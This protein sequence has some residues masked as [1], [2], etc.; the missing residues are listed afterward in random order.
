LIRYRT[1]DRTRLMR[2][3]CACG[4][5]TVRMDRVVGRTDDM[6]IVRGVNVFPS[7]IETVLLQVGEVAPHY[8]IIVD[9]STKHIDELDVLVE[10]PAE[11]YGDAARLGMLEKRLSY[12]VQSALGISCNVKLTAPG[13]I[14]RSEGKA[15]RVVDKRKDGN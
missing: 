6:L 1:R 10:A 11:L 4:R 9:R 8:Q 13:G 5:T 2:D 3:T 7:Q 12:E 14:A 15:Q